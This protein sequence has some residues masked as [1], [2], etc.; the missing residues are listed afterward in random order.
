MKTKIMMSFV[1]LALSI[2]VVC[3][4]NR[5]GSGPSPPKII[6][7]IECN[8][9]NPCPSIGNFETQCIMM[10]SSGFCGMKNCNGRN[11]PDSC[12]RVKAGKNPANQEIYHNPKGCYRRTCRY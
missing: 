7:K 2:H 6:D 8:D 5:G 11:W 3:A 12:S 1:L 10:G 4:R 9:G